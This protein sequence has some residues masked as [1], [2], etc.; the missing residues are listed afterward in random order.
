LGLH[1]VERDRN[2][3]GT[4]IDWILP[5]EA[6]PS[7]NEIIGDAPVPPFSV[8]GDDG[9]RTPFDPSKCSSGKQT[10]EASTDPKWIGGVSI[11]QEFECECGTFTRHTV[12]YKGQI[13]HDHFRPG[14]AKGG[15][16]D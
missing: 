4:I 13:V 16:N 11:E 10:I 15:G 6:T 7:P 14:S 8:P 9:K 1:L 12:I 5:S 3:I 2:P